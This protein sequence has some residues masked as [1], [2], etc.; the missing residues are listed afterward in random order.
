M[1][2]R[3]ELAL[4]GALGLLER[5]V[6]YARSSLHLVTPADLTSP[7]PCSEWDLRALLGHMS[8]SLTALHEA[9]VFGQVGLEAAEDHPD[10]DGDADIVATIRGKA[11]AL[12]GAW[13]HN[14]GA[15]LISIAGSPL[16]AGVLAST[17]ALEIAVHGWDVAQ[18][19][20]R[21]HPIPPPLAE[22]LLELVPF[23]VSQQDR[24]ARFAARVELPATAPKDGQLLAA[25]GRQI[26]PAGHRPG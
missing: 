23:L 16:T 9:A 5:A 14:D 20:R 26:P 8:D 18:A 2:A 17:G 13:T 15:D 12:L 6:G 22:E 10:G 3:Q 7:T 25:L 24:P 4:I 19:C 11:C 21:P 1:Y